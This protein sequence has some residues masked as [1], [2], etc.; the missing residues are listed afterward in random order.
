MANPVLA[1][2]YGL[3][4]VKLFLDP[5]EDSI[6]VINSGLPKIFLD[7]LGKSDRKHAHIFTYAIAKRQRATVER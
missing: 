3:R 2:P 4:D 5:I 6:S 7:T 1:L